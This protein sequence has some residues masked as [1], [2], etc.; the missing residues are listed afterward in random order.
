MTVDSAE[1]T[2]ERIHEI[3]GNSSRAEQFATQ[4]LAH[5]DFDLARG[6][7]TGTVAVVPSASGP[8]PKKTAAPSPKKRA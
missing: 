1:E 8:A 5:R 3:L 6:K 7:K 4:F 2:R